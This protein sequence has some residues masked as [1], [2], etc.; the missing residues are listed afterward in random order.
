MDYESRVVRNFLSSLVRINFSYP[1]IE[2]HWSVILPP[3]NHHR[4]E[5]G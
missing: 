3:K 4:A 2:R 5:K 1:S